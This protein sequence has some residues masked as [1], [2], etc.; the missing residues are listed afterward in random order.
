[1]HLA[2]AYLQT[3]SPTLALHSKDDINKL[4]NQILMILIN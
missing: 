3:P 4:I 2:I 1:M